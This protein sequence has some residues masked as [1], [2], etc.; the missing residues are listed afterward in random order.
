[1]PEII[2]GID[3]GT[4]EWHAL[5]LGSIG[6]SSINAVLSKGEGKMRKDL[7]N[8]LAA[9]VLTGKPTKNISRYQFDR[10]H[11]YEP[12][13]RD[14]Y[15]F[16]RGVDVEQV[17][18]IRGDVAQT[19]HSPDGLIGDDGGL[20]IKVREPHVF[21]ELLDNGKIPLADRRQCQFFFFISGRQWI[22]Y[23][24]FCPEFP[25]EKRLL[26]NRV[27]PSQSDQDEIVTATNGFLKDL[28]A[29]VGK[30]G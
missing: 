11:E 10:G 30:I 18:L 4:E 27:Y 15:A 12:D 14:L 26:I 5:R 8:R 25:I 1:M 16:I 9:E 7:M 19:H 17:A 13:A 21:V 6:G 2:R 28:A 23:A 29:L 20:E 24:N 22:D 3:Q